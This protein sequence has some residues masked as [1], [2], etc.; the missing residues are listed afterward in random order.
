MEHFIPCFLIEW[1]ARAKDV[2]FR[3]EM[4]QELGKMLVLWKHCRVAQFFGLKTPMMFDNNS[5]Y[6]TGFAATASRTV[7]FNACAYSSIAACA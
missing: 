1:G 3:Y 6:A 2:V 5:W 7:P 4:S